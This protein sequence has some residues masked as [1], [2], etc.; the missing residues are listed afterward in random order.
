MKRL[1][2]ALAL[3]AFFL[4]AMAGADPV[5]GPLVRTE[6]VD[7][8]AFLVQLVNLQQ[9][10]T[11]LRIAELNGPTLFAK[12]VK[13]HNGYRQKFDFSRMEPG[14]YLFTVSHE[15]KDYHVVVYLN[16]ERLLLSDISVNG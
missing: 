8:K 2:Y 5:D 10:K 3:A 15:G 16:E 6:Q 14:R 9:K 13:A 12:S 1:L 11:F 4:P 7:D